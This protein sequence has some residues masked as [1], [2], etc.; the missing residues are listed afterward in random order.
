MGIGEGCDAGVVWC[1]FDRVK[2]VSDHEIIFILHGLVVRV[3]ANRA[4]TTY[5]VRCGL[6][7]R[8]DWFNTKPYTD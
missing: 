6:G 5:A 3:D 8:F 4:K 1:G 7:S 2:P